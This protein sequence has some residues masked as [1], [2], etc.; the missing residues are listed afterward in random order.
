[1]NSARLSLVVIGLSALA[2][3]GTGSA[4]A[5]FSR[6]APIGEMFGPAAAP[7]P[8]PPAVTATVAV[9]PFGDRAQPAAAGTRRNLFRERE[10]RT[11]APLVARSS[12]QMSAP[13]PAG[14]AAPPEV[15][16]G[17]R[18]TLAGLAE[19]VVSG[20]P[21]R[22]AV[23]SGAGDVWIVR[24]GDVVAGRYRVEAIGPGSVR[25]ADLL[26]GAPYVVRF[27]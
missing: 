21:V 6:P 23:L 10:P 17:P 8:G 9:R 16:P 15:P 11:P 19:Q 4:A 13:V 20:V 26:G 12:D 22:T 18:V 24:E 5:C 2:V 25:L 1:M 14:V 27:R 3:W 7:A